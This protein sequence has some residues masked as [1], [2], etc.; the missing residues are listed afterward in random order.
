MDLQD[1][2]IDA[3][4]GEKT[5]PVTTIASMPYGLATIWAQWAIRLIVVV[6]VHPDV[7]FR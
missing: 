3:P 7:A 2:A 1:G 6:K 5:M 4:G